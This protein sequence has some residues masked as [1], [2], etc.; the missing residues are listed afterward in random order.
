MVTKIP[1]ETSKGMRVYTVQREPVQGLAIIRKGG[2]WFIVH[3]TSGCTVT[4]FDQSRDKGLSL[5]A[6]SKAM[7][8]AS[9][10]DEILNESEAI[11]WTL[12]ADYLYQKHSQASAWTKNVFQ[13]IDSKSNILYI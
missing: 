8:K 7:V 10:I 4:G 13:I 6:V 3:I 11:N 9:Q 2:G 5:E 1:V 12:G